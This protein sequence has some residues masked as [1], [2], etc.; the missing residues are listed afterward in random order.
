[1]ALQD[2]S[3]NPSAGAAYF[4][5]NTRPWRRYDLDADGWVDQ[6]DWDIVE[7]QIAQ[8]VPPLNDGIAPS[9]AVVAP[10]P[11]SAVA[12]R[13]YVRLRG[14]VW[15]NAGLRRIEYRVND[16]PLC[17]ISEPAPQTGHGSPYYSC[18]WETP[19]KRGAYRIT[20]TAVDAAGTTTVSAPLWVQVQ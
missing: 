15:D 5:S 11:G 3:P 20:V 18:W 16:K 14:H 12:R 2:I 17:A 4:H 7:Q 1:M 10:A 13:S 19:N 6:R 8:P 9:A